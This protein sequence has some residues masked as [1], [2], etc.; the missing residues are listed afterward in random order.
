M[1]R[2]SWFLACL[3]AACLALGAC[4]K[5]DPQAAA[6]AAA[7]KRTPSL[8]IVSAEG[9]GFTVGSMMSAQA[10]YVFF[11]PQCPHCAHLWEAS[12]PLQKKLKF[13]WMP[14]AFINASSAPQG[15]ALLSAA[16]PAARM[17]EH[18]ASILAGKG[19]TSASSSAA[20]EMEKA[21]RN[22]TQLFNNLGLESVPFVIA[23]NARTGQT[24]TRTGALDTAA[25]AELLGVDAQ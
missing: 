11:D 1:H 2:T 7:P 4:S 20:P 25:L 19:G 6:A 15:V 16:D 24:V 5:Q 17:A 13:V 21:V 18:E 9:K 12:V 22:N 10:V 23:R 8:E 3:I 14:V